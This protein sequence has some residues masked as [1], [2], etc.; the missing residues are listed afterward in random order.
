VRERELELKA[1]LGAID[2]EELKKV[3]ESEIE[4]EVRSGVNLQQIADA[5]PKLAEALDGLRTDTEQNFQRQEKVNQKLVWLTAPT[6][7]MTAMGLA[8]AILT[9]RNGLR[10]S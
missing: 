10:Y 5:Q 8:V 9:R 3:T 7:V 4:R 2:S 1:L 6:V